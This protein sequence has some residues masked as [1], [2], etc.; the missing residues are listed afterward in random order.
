MRMA[1]I[2]MTTNNTAAIS[3]LES[4]PEFSVHCSMGILPMTSIHIGKILMPSIHMG[5]L[6]M[7]LIKNLK[8]L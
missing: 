6:P 1:M 8:M 5:I 7:L 4:P 3:L 2:A